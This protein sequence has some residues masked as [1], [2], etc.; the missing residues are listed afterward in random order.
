MIEISIC[1]SNKRANYQRTSHM[2]GHMTNQNSSRMMALQFSMT[3]R[4]EEA[5]E[6]NHPVNR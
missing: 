1:Y 4:E 5:Y 3:T 2:G 6:R